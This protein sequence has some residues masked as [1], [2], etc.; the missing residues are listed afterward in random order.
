MASLKNQNSL[1]GKL[2]KAS[3]E[4]LVD[5]KPKFK[6]KLVKHTSKNSKTVLISKGLKGKN[7]SIQKP[8]I[9]TLQTV[10]KHTKK[11]SKCYA[12]TRFTKKIKKI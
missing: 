10:A 11:A 2:S 6:W 5:V 3:T 9:K 4:S 1:K 7:S 8:H 12:K